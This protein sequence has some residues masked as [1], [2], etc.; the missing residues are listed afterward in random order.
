MTIKSETH[1]MSIIEK[2]NGIALIEITKDYADTQ[3]DKRFFVVSV[4]G[5]QV[6]SAVPADCP[7]SGSWYGALTVGGVAYVA[8]GRTYQTARRWFNKLAAAEVE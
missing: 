1:S 5:N 8:N 2:R 7:D 3:A 4:S 6:Y